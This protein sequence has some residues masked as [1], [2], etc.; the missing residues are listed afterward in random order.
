MIRSG[1]I[2]SRS[3]AAKPGYRAGI[4]GLVIFLSANLRKKH[5]EDRPVRLTWVTTVLE[6]EQEPTEALLKEGRKAEN[7]DQEPQPKS[8]QQ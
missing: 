2:Q 6:K 8:H 5:K 4:S 1:D 3:Q 7:R